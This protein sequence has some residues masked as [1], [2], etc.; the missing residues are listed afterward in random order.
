MLRVEL[1][2]KNTLKKYDKLIHEFGEHVMYSE[3]STRHG[4][5][6]IETFF[7]MSLQDK[8]RFNNDQFRDTYLEMFDNSFSYLVDEYSPIIVDIF[9]RSFQKNP[10]DRQIKIMTNHE[11]LVNVVAQIK[12]TRLSQIIKTRLSHHRVTFI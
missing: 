6:M 3:Y 1:L 2:K 7:F 8:I 12:K 11:I 4:D 5:D 9:T 10:V